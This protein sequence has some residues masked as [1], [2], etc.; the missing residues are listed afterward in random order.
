MADYNIEVKAKLNVTQYKQDVQDKLRGVSVKV[1][2]SI[3]FDEKT[4]IVGLPKIQQS[5]SDYLKQNPVAI[6]VTL[7][8]EEFKKNINDIKD[9]H[10]GISFDKDDLQTLSDKILTLNKLEEYFK[11]N[12]INIQINTPT[13]DN[14]KSVKDNIEEYFKNNPVNVNFQTSSDNQSGAASVQNTFNQ[15]NQDIQNTFNQLNQTLQNITNNVQ[16][17]TNNIDNSVNNTTRNVQNNTLEIDNSINNTTR[18]VQNN[19]LR[20]GDAIR[21]TLDQSNRQYNTFDNSINVRLNQTTRYIQ[22]NIQRINDDVEHANNH[23]NNLLNTLM[24]Y[25]GITRIIGAV[26]N[27]FQKMVQ[28]V[29]DLD[30]ELTEFSKVTDLSTQETEKFIDSAYRLGDTVARTGTEVV[31]ATTLFKKMG[32]EI[33][34]SMKFAEDALMWTNVADGMVGVEDAATMLISTMKAFEEQ[35]VSS[36]HVIDA[37][38]E[39]SNKY[40]TSSSALSENLSVVAATLATS[41]TSFEQMV[42]L[43]TAGI[44]IMP[45]RASK[46]A[47]GLKTIS[48]RIRQIEGDTADKLDTFFAEKGISRF[49][50]ITGQLRGTYDILYDVSKIWGTLTEN[51]KQ[52]IGETMAGKNQITV[53]NALMMNF[54]TAI[55]ATETALNSAGSAAKENERVLDSIQGHIQRFQSAFEELSHHLIDSGV[56]KQVVD[57]GTFLIK[58]ID[59]IA[60]NP[61]TRSGFFLLISMLGSNS[62]LNNIERVGNRIEEIISTVRSFPSSLDPIS[63]GIT[64]IIAALGVAYNIIRESNEE[65]ERAKQNIIEAREKEEESIDSKIR[66][67]EELQKKYDLENLTK[68]EQIE[69]LRQINELNEG[70][71]L[72]HGNINEE[73]RLQNEKLYIQKSLL[74]GINE[75]ASKSAISFDS[76][77]LGIKD[78]TRSILDLNESVSSIVFDKSGK[79]RYTDLID[80]DD[81]SVNI[82]KD[83]LQGIL[84]ALNEIPVE[85]R[86]LDWLNIYDTVSGDLKAIEGEIDNVNKYARDAVSNMLQATGRNIKTMSDEE[87]ED[88][89]NQIDGIKE[90]TDIVFTVTTDADQIYQLGDMINDEIT[91]RAEAGAANVSDA[92]DEVAVSLSGA[93][94][95]LGDYASQA[96]ILAQA[97]DDITNSGQITAETLKPARLNHILR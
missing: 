74:A 94:A 84:D 43:M 22:N 69:I 78:A 42:G 4:R 47:N 16:N 85:S 2:P 46:V 73:I 45:D 56:F 52:F 58:V 31:Q 13:D 5:I 34:E 3:N 7:N 44:E 48:Q 55:N 32:Y 54:K 65:V 49:D 62:I 10:I 53:L 9:I 50:E 60:S 80:A 27:S 28:E 39:V 59:A 19:T 25:F 97:Q 1:S 21:N 14:L 95:M 88:L 70:D 91:A 6:N 61:L 87:L 75:E 23:A 63:L 35:G 29:R 33:G 8:E 72:V 86:G 89:K 12:K 20:I 11:S 64:A 83:T 38:N 30:V 68:E 77:F 66:K 40:S 90:K 76:G 71:Y 18:N 92:M 37:L 17:I 57:I 82:K 26:Q 36:T 15:L 67:Y 96:E 51:E 24:Q 41:G 93:I 81:I 79:I